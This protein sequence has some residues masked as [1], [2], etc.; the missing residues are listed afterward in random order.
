MPRKYLMHHDIQN[1][2]SFFP[3]C[4][5]KEFK[6]FQ[7]LETFKK[8]YANAPSIY[9]EI[10]DLYYAHLITKNDKDEIFTLLHINACISSLILKGIKTRN[11]LRTKQTFWP[12]TKGSACAWVQ[13]VEA[14]MEFEPLLFFTT[15]QSCRLFL[16]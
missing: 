12:S 1:F 11:F 2:C 3:I 15:L 4:K 16:F 8:R 10:R 5:W 6:L 9:Q 14:L 7:L 13:R